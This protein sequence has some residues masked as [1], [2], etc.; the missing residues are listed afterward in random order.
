MRRKPF[1]KGKYD[2]L[3]P[4]FKSVGVKPPPFKAY[5]RTTEPIKKAVDDLL[6]HA[7]RTDFVLDWDQ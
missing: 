1:L 6:M 3:L 2:A 4:R 7:C 5:Q